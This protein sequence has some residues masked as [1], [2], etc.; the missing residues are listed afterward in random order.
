MFAQIGP[1]AVDCARFFGDFDQTRT[2]CSGI[3]RSFGRVPPMMGQHRR[4]STKFGTG[5][6]KLGQ[7]RSTS[8]FIRPDSAIFGLTS[9]ELRTNLIKCD[10][11][12]PA[13]SRHCSAGDQSWPSSDQ[14]WPEFDQIWFDVGQIWATRRGGATLGLE[15]SVNSFV[16]S[17]ALLWIDAGRS[18]EVPRVICSIFRLPARAGHRRLDPSPRAIAPASA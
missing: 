9:T 11:S 18:G 6:S 8:A 16:S 7:I 12:W 13:G 1:I 17:R 4:S 3:D 15:R 14:C 2:I 10:Q 5:T